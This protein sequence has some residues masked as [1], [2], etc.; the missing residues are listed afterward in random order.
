MGVN[1]PNPFFGSCT[2]P[3]S[4]SGLEL[5]LN[6]RTDLSSELRRAQ[7]HA[8]QGGLSVLA[9]S[10]AAAEHLVQSVAPVAIVPASQKSLLVAAPFAPRPRARRPTRKV[11]PLALA[12]D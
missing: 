3:I 7:E 2:L 1:A 5:R 6:E 12:E 8:H 11:R 4:V 9:E 10:L